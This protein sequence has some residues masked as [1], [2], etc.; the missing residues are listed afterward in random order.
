MVLYMLLAVAI[1]V[2]LKEIHF[3]VA[4]HLACKAINKKGFEDS[5]EIMGA[6][7]GTQPGMENVPGPCLRGCSFWAVCAL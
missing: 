5:G 1:C 3:G 6:T 2:P 7:S 4:W